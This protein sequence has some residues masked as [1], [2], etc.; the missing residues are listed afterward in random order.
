M[1]QSGSGSSFPKYW[2]SAILVFI[3]REIVIHNFEEVKLYKYLSFYFLGL[4][5]R[6]A[7]RAT[8]RPK[9]RIPLDF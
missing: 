9:L 6:P 2:G 5:S 1:Q 3:I 4:D 7:E 8:K